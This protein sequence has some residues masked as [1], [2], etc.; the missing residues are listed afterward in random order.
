MV[1]LLADERHT[2]A[3]IILRLAWKQGL[4]REEMQRL[5]W[6][7]IAPDEGGIHLPD[8]TVPLEEET[9]SCLLDR[10]AFLDGVTP[11]VVVSDRRRQQMPRE[12]ISRLARQ[13]L[14]RAGIASISLMDLRHDFIIRQLE[15]HD[16]PYV[17]RISGIAVHTLYATFSD[18][19]PRTQPAPAEDPPEAYAFLLWKVLQSQGSSLVGLALWL[20]WKLGMQAREI[21]ALTWSQVD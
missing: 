9:A 18:Y 5:T 1:R 14:D 10:Y 15:A 21:L 17:A 6:A 12:S 16:W 20:G 8:R 7:D 19:L 11:Y 3:G 13:A 4:T 2:A